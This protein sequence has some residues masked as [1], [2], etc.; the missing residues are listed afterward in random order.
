MHRSRLTLICLFLL[1]LPMSAWAAY[2]MPNTINLKLD[3]LE[4]SLDTKADGPQPDSIKAPDRIEYD[5]MQLARGHRLSINDTTIIYPRFIDFCLRVYRWAERTFNTYDPEYVSGTGKHGKVRLLT[6]NWAGSYFFRLED[7]TPLVMVSH[8]YSNIGIQANYSIVGLSF[9]IEPG[10]IFSGHVSHHKKLGFSFSCSRLFAEAYY[11]QNTGGSVLKK[12]GNKK[13]GEI[14]RLPFEGID[15]RVYGAL[16]FYIFN[17]KKF[18]YSSAYNLSNYQLKSSGSWILGATGAIYNC[19]FDFTKLPDEVKNQVITPQEKYKLNYNSVNII[20]GYSYNWVMNRHFL[21]N[22]TALPGIGVSFSFDDS[23]PGRRDLISM[24][25]KGC[26]SLTYTSRQFFITGT[27]NFT[28]NYFLTKSVGFMSGIANF[29]LS[30]G[31][32]F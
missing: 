27:S 16:G 18:S 23:S 6:D 1:I 13:S 4:L 3:T 26:M 10:T 14:D 31:I 28:G 5:W 17:Y 22:I 12:A 11:W 30:T 29:Q 20:G 15:F 7:G 25:G 2:D 24:A 9:S 19:N 21:F 8:L 32:R